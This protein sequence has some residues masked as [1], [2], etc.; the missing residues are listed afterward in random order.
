MSTLYIA[1][2]MTRIS[3]SSPF[4]ILSQKSNDRSLAFHQGGLDKMER[5]SNIY[6][7]ATKCVVT[8]YV[9]SSTPLPLGHHN[10]TRP[11]ARSCGICRE[12]SGTGADF[13]SILRFPLPILIPPTAPHSLINLSSDATY[14]RYCQCH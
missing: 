3:T 2:Y 8:G 5:S 4:F 1:L 14:S 13:L 11:P 7:S 10:N 12:R 9:A 6:I